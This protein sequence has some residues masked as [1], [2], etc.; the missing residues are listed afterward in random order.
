MPG[1]EKGPA[2]HQCPVN[3]RF[4]YCANWQGVRPRGAAPWRR[5]ADMS[6]EPHGLPR[7]SRILL[8]RALKWKHLLSPDSLLRP[9]SQTPQPT[10]HPHSTDGWITCSQHVHRSTLTL[11]DRGSYGRDWKVGFPDTLGYQPGLWG[12]PSLSP[13]WTEPQP[14]SLL[15]GSVPSPYRLN[16]R[17]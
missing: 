12:C 5:P 15:P 2:N 17:V 11:P 3:N 4:C 14:I 7:D 1:T 6:S 10:F 13:A 9:A 8:W 16:K